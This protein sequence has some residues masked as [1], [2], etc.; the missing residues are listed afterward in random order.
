MIRGSLTEADWAR[1]RDYTRTVSKFV[2]TDKDSKARISPAAFLRIARLQHPDMPLLPHLSDLVIEDADAS[3]TYLDLLLTPSLKTLKASCIP[4]AQQSTF[5]SFLTA[6]EQEVPLLQTLILGPGLF[7]PSSLQTISQ[8]NSLCHL[9]LKLEDSKLPFAFFDNIGSLAMLKTFILDARYVSGTMTGDEPTVLPPFP[10]DNF[11]NS[12]AMDGNPADV[13]HSKT[14]RPMCSFNQLAVLHVIGWL[15]LLEDLIHRVTSTKLEDVSVTFIRLSYDELKVSLAKEKAVR[16]M[17]AEEGRRRE[18]A[19]RKMKEQEKLLKE[20]MER[21]RMD[22]ERRWREEAEKMMEEQERLLKE[23]MEREID[24]E[25]RLREE[26]EMMEEQEKMWEDEM[27]PKMDEEWQLADEKMM[28][29]QE[30]LLKEV[31]ERIDEERRLEVEAEERRLKE[32]AEERRLK[33]EAEERRL[34][35]DAEE[36]RLKEEAEETRLK[37]AEDRRLKEEAEL[38]EWRLREEAD[39]MMEEQARERLLK[40][41][42]EWNRIDEEGWC[43]Y[44]PQPSFPPPFPPPSSSSLWHINEFGMQTPTE[45]TSEG[46]KKKIKLTKK[47]EVR[48]RLLNEQEIPASLSFEAHTLSFTKVLRKLCLPSLKSLYVCQWG[49]SFQCLLKPSTLPEEV[50]RT[51]LLLPAIESLEVKGW[52]LDSVEG[53]LSAA[54]TI[55][56]LKCLLLPPGK[57]NSSISLPTLRHVAKTCPKLES[58]QCYIDPL[59]SVPEYSIPTDVGLSH[60]LRTLSVGSSFPHPVAKQLGYLIARHLYLLFPKLKTIKNSEEHNAELWISVD[61][62]VKIFQTARMDDLNRQ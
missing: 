56:N 47:L 21:K 19:E 8:F 57:P 7:L 9:E 34:K 33:E 17:K 3:I 6:I 5:S 62:F 25:R 60:G 14:C 1:L 12:N 37:E 39:K 4:D 29:E 42:M 36:R 23:E 61:E 28:E 27:K 50:F 53:V 49:V 24:E 51:M 59:S 20:V 52:V 32:E 46:R 48:E 31:R 44:S 13:R 26:A 2:V 38:E 10:S 15:P 54:E 45:V 35:E 43:S 18:E 30:R 11:P 41:E 16:E 58:F 55:P 22:E 40:G